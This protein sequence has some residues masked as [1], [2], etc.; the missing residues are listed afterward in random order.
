MRVSPDGVMEKGLESC[1]GQWSAFP[2][3]ARRVSQPSRRGGVHTSFRGSIH[4]GISF[5]ACVIPFAVGYVL[6]IDSVATTSGVD[7]PLSGFGD[8]RDEV[9]LPVNTNAT[10]LRQNETSYHPSEDPTSAPSVG[11]GTFPSDSWM[12]FA[13]LQSRVVMAVSW[14][15]VRGFLWFGSC[16]DRGT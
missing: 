13:D 12:N 8:P 1:V 14:W 10:G 3:R 2:S 16:L 11:P 9:S 15:S 4:R 7:Q 6:C 5:L